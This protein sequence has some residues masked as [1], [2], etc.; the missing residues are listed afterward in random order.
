MGDDVAAIEERTTLE[1]EHALVLTR[2]SRYAEAE[3]HL[4]AA[5]RL[6]E[7]LPEDDYLRRAQVLTARAVIAENWKADLEEAERMST[8]ALELQRRGGVPYVIADCLNNLAIIKNSR[9]KYDEAI[10][11]YEEA[12][13]L[14]RKTYGDHHPV[15]AVTLENLGSVYMRQGE[16]AKTLALL[17]EVLAIREAAS[18]RTALP[19]RGPDSTWEWSRAGAA[20]TRAPTSLIDAGLKIFREQYGEKSNE[21]AV[22]FFYR[23]APARRS[24]VS[25]P[26]AAT[27]S[28]ASRSPTRSPP[29]PTSTGSTRSTTW[30][31][32]IAGRAGGARPRLGRSGH[33]RARPW[34]RRPQGLD[35]A[36]RGGA[37]DSVAADRLA[38]RA[39]GSRPKI[40]SPHVPSCRLSP[41]PL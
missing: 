9:G 8:E 15:V 37:R 17:D 34:Q 32:S 22:G 5:D 28:R 30:R 23:G 40:P 7:R 10:V 20:T 12:I 26:R 6:I 38:L 2:A 3:Q 14:S 18:V 24:G 36:F 41:R 29:P 13:A 21:A 25:T 19:P 27:T 1:Y 16:Y 4:D 35:R 33:E 31:G 11:L 39:S